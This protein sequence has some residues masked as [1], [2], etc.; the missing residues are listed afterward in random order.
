[1]KV[2]T[3]RAATLREALDKVKRDLGADAFILGQREIRPSN[4]LGLVQKARVEVTAAVDPSS[5]PSPAEPAKKRTE[6]K[7]PAVDAVDQVADRVQISA[8]A[9]PTSGNDQSVLDEIRK[10]NAVIQSMSAE[11]KSNVVWLKPKRFATSAAKELYAVLASGGLDEKLAASV[12]AEANGSLDAAA[13][14]LAARIQIDDELIPTAAPVRP[15]VVTFLG[16]TGVGKTTTI[17]KI[18]ADAAFNKMLKVGMVTLDNFRIAAIEQLKTYG[19]IM[20]ISVHAAAGVEE[21]ASAVQSLSDRDLILID[22]AGRSH[23][24]IA[25]EWE[26]AN[27]LNNSVDMKRA[28][29]LSAT[30]QAAD[31]AEIVDRYAMFNPSSL[32]FT[33]LD[34]TTTHGTILNE[35][36][37]CNKP[38][39]YVTTG[40]A[41]P[42]DIVK[43]QA[44]QLVDLS[45]G[46]NRAESWKNLVHQSRVPAVS[47]PPKQM[48]KITRRQSH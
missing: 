22:T 12:A 16:P 34:E 21:L 15:Q 28:L 31:L 29:V 24:E 33:K 32:I 47:N 39:A 38:L 18:A 37:R 19:E 9:P 17:A 26:L 3:Y 43:P 44:R 42:L 7:L 23:R 14:S 6:R 10:L 48:N 40:Q 41:V 45:I 13:A 46:K 2:K 11:R 35:L 30:T 36:I 27:F 20:G 25:H 8:A 5:M 4:L 1:M